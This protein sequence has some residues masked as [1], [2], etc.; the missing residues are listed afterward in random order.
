MAQEDKVSLLVDFADR[1]QKSGHFDADN[2]STTLEQVLERQDI[3]LIERR[4]HF[5]HRF[6]GERGVTMTQFVDV[7]N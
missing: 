4:R 7:I 3:E 5:W 2:I 1:L 6:V